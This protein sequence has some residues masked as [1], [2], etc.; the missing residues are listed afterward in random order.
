MHVCHKDGDSS[1]NLWKLSHRQ[2]EFPRI[3]ESKWP[4]WPWRSESMTSIFNTSC[5]YPRMHVWCKF[6][7]S[8]PNLWRVIERKAKFPRILRQNSQ[9]DL[10][11]Q[12]QWPPFSIPAESI[13]LCMFGANLVIPAQTCDLLSCG[14]QWR[15]QFVFHD[16][17]LLCSF[18]VMIACTEFEHNIDLQ[19]IL[20]GY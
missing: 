2:A 4:K 8:R 16:N 14:P 1:P 12:G 6:G 11:G 7:D 13:P 5:E 20:T 3:L 19:K 15:Q 17:S 10:K 18:T 9:N